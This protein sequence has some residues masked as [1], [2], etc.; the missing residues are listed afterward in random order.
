MT[1]SS[2]Q[3][4]LSVLMPLLALRAPSWRDLVRRIAHEQHA[5]VVEL[6]HAAA[7]EG[8]DADPFQLELALVAQHGLDARDDVSGFFSA[9]GRRPSRAGK[10]MRQTLS[11]CLCSSTD[12]LGWKGGS[13]QN[14]RSAGVVGLRDHVGDQEAVHEDLP[15]MSSPSMLRIGELRAVG[16]HQPISGQV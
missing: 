9:S 11:A 6:A 15:S 13:N 16:G 14:Q 8:V 2:F 7:L 3:A 12:W 1:S 4:R 10:S 5:V